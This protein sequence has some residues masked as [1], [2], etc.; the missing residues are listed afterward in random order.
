MLDGAHLQGGG[1]AAGCCSRVW[2][3]RGCPLQ[4]VWLLRDAPTGLTGLLFFSLWGR[5]PVTKVVLEVVPPLQKA[6]VTIIPDANPCFRHVAWGPCGCCPPS[7]PALCGE[8]RCLGVLGKAPVTKTYKNGDPSRQ[9]LREE[10]LPVRCTGFKRGSVATAAVFLTY[11]FK[12]VPWMCT[13]YPHH[14]GRLC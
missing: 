1:G 5:L 7:L 9:Q 13:I 2:P 4:V 10:A 8:V 12:I 6:D 3:P 11:V 14:L